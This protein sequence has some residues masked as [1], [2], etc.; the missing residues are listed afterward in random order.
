MW[1]FLFKLQSWNS[2][3]TKVLAFVAWLRTSTVWLLWSS[4]LR[5]LQPHSDERALEKVCASLCA[6]H[7]STPSQ[8]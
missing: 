2:V 5:N 7:I 8:L 3:S 1:S 6:R 4:H